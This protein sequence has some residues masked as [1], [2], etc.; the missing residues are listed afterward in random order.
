M[1]QHEEYSDTMDN[2]C[3][4]FCRRINFALRKIALLFETKKYDECATLIRRMNSVTLG[5]ILTEVPLEV[6]FTVFVGGFC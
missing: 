5:N 3:Y 4:S 2:I 6:L 1:R